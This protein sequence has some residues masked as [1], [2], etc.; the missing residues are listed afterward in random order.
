MVV[1]ADKGSDRVG[2][3]FNPGKD[4]NNMLTV[5]EAMMYSLSWLVDRNRYC[6]RGWWSTYKHEAA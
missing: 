6:S 4:V 3:R 2:G 5:W 1:A